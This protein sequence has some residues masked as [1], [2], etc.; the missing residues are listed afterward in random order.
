[1]KKVEWDQTFQ[2][3]VGSKSRGGKRGAS[4]RDTSVQPKSQSSTTIKSINYYNNPM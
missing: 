4:T 2:G 3:R 1:M